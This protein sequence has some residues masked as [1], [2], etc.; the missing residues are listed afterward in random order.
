MYFSL[1]VSL[2]M[3]TAG[4]VLFSYRQS[5]NGYCGGGSD[6]TQ[7]HSGQTHIEKHNPDQAPSAESTKRK[8]A[9]RSLSL[10]QPRRR[11]RRLLLLLLLLFPQALL[12]HPV[13]NAKGV[14]HKLIRRFFCQLSKQ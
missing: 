6:A 12:P 5:F 2:S 4:A 13:W 3:V 1:T 11:G 14:F 8:A 9:S 7:A 10:L